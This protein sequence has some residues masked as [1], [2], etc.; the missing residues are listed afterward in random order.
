MNLFIFPYCSYYY[1]TTHMQLQRELYNEIHLETPKLKRKKVVYKLICELL[2]RGYEAK[3]S[4]PPPLSSE[5]T[6]VD[7]LSYP[8]PP[9]HLI[10]LTPVR[11]ISALNQGNSSISKLTW[12][13]HM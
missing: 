11:W 13:L 6:T 7:V 9:P 10:Y 4:P 5:M 8:T 2:K 12:I 3:C 1:V